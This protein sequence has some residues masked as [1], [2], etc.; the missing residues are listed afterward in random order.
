MEGKKLTNFNL[1]TTVYGNT[2][3]SGIFLMIGFAIGGAGRS[4]PL[5][6]LLGAVYI[7]MANFASYIIVSF[8][9][10]EGGTY[11][12][13][14]FVGKPF[15]SGVSGLNTLLSTTMLGG[16]A[17]GIVEYASAVFPQIAPYSK[18]CWLSCSL[19]ST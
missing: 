4:L 3:G 11:D 14:A 8:A 17:S 16:F 1:F 2:I 18:V 12:H 9:P 10:L 7:T 5:A 15:F 13:A 6:V 19:A